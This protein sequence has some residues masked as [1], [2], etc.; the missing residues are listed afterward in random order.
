MQKEWIIA[1]EPDHAL[2][3]AIAGDNGLHPAIAGV[4]ASRGFDRNTAS[5]HLNPSLDDLHD[6]LQMKDMEKA[7]DRLVNAIR[8]KEKVV[9]HGDYDVDGIAGVALLYLFLQRHNC[10]VDYYIPDR[11][12]EGYGLSMRGVGWTADIGASVLVTVDVGTSDLKEVASA[13]ERGVDVIVTDHHEPGLSL[14][15]TFAMLNPKCGDSGYPFHGLSGCGVAFKLRQAVSKAL[16]EAPDESYRDL[17]LVALATVCD[18]VPL[19]GE[20]RILAKFGMELLSGSSRPGV[21]ALKRVAGIDGKDINVY[22]LGFILGPR[23][24]AAGRIA[25]ATDGLKLLI[26]EEEDEAEHLA[27][28]LDTQNER[29]KKLNEAIFV[30]A[31]EMVDGELALEN[32]AGIVLASPDWHEGV[33]GIVAS[34]IAEKYHRPTVVISTDGETGKGSA[35]SVKGFN[36]HAG[37]ERCSALLR[38]FGGHELAA[39]LLIDK[40]KIPALREMF[41]AVVKE[42]VLIEDMTPKVF[43]DKYLAIREIDGELFSSQE[44]MKPFGLG[45]PRPVFLSEDVDVV[46][47]PRVVGRNHLKFKV[48][49]GEVVHDT[50]AFQMGDM[51]DA[52]AVGCGVELAY[53]I[54]EDEFRGRKTLTL[55]VK[56]LRVKTAGGERTG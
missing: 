17:D 5:T 42:D 39:G 19:I 55:H 8:R 31:C 25:S 4:L 33:I 47:T 53:T 34:R 3:E 37:L 36:L 15:S 54:R 44:R 38:S 49:D 14:P 46:G 52:V 18:V 23:L 16:D 1:R 12:E 56:D 26:A 40:D 2:A 20:N 41:N 30:E 28:K 7:V 22:H 43:I 32:T 48:R 13:G 27:E 10:P 45:N 11:I 50:I 35:R 24:N 21:T 29:R 6:P 9:I 51:L